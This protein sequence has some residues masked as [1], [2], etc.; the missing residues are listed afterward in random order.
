MGFAM[1][2][3]IGTAECLAVVVLA[4]FLGPETKGKVLTAD[5]EVIRVEAPA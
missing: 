4:V 2:M 1:P 3:L 5:I